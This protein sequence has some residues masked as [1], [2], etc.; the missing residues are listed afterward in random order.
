MNEK[1]KKALDCLNGM[2]QY[3]KEQKLSTRILDGIDEC[4]KQVAADD[5]K[6]NEVNFAV[7]DIFKSIEQKTAPV[8]V[9]KDNDKNEISIQEIRAQIVKMAERCHAE[10]ETSMGMMA[11]RKNAV[12]QKIYGE[13]QEI[14]YIKA[15][16]K[17]LKDENIY[18]EFYKKVKSKYEK[19]VF[20]LIKEMLGDICNNY[21]YMLEHMK[22]MFQ[23]IGGYAAGVSNKTFYYEYTEKKEGL[24]KKI[25]S[26]IESSEV[27]GSEIISFGIRTKETIKDIKKK[28]NKKIK[29][30]MMTPIFMVLTLLLVCLSVKVITLINENKAVI[31]KEEEKE[32]PEVK[33]D[34]E[35]KDEAEESNSEIEKI[36]SDVMEVLGTVVTSEIKS[37][38][39]SDTFGSSVGI[40]MILG[41]VVLIIVLYVIYII[42]LK[43]WCNY[44]IRKRCG[45]FLQTETIQFAQNNTLMPKLDEA[46]K[47]AVEEYESQY[48]AILNSIFS[49]TN[50]DMDNTQN[51]KQ[52]HFTVLKEEWNALRYE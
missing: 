17:E 50:Y 40:K 3:A 48:L 14:S 13:I 24:D 25:Q 32:N 2:E 38:M 35:I 47:T 19:N 41:I 22:S 27:G 7:E 45:E 20:Q 37:E 16:S 49:G 36:T 46:M 42:V 1:Q 29:L 33:D 28:V 34:A 21:N 31:E 15:H 51:K 18:L 6:W 4:K 44:Q 9:Y 26:E 30:L 11:E 23:S 39:I 8:S 43:L 52:D 12:L 10:N 5:T